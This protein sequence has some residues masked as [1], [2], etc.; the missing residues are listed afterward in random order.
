MKRIFFV[1]PA[2]NEEKGVG[3]VVDGLRKAGYK[4]IVVVN[5]G[6]KDKTAEIAEKAGAT[7]LSHI[8]N[9]GQGAG[10]RTGTEYA[11]KHG[12]DVIV[13]FD[14]DG[15]HRVK[16][17]PAMLKP[18]VDGKVDATLGSRFLKKTN[19]PTKK[20]IGLKIAIFVNYVLYGIKLSDA[21][22]GFRVLSKKAANEIKIASDGMEHA[23]EIVE[24]LHRNKLKYKEVPVVILYPP[25]Q[26]GH[27]HSPI[28]WIKTGLKLIYNKFLK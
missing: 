21:H 7:V 27:N 26:Q 24:E 6:S 20:K 5:D 4:N 28:A 23:S 25:G 10:L 1:I 13:H 19:L 15:Q 11:L 9:R 12:A 17:L 8:I 22:N 2:W 3:K 16:D 18:V 14:S